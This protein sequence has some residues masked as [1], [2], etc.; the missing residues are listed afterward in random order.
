VEIGLQSSGPGEGRLWTLQS[1]GI[2]KGPFDGTFQ[3]VDRTLGKS[4]LIIDAEGMVSVDVLQIMGG[5]DIAEPFQMSSQ[6][7]QEGSV[8]IIDEDHPGQLKLSNRAYDQRVAGIVSGANGIKAGLT[9][10]SQNIAD[11]GQNV[12]LTGRV[13][14]M[15]DASSSPIRPGDLL[16]TSDT[17]GYCMKMTDNSRGRGAVLGK[18]MTSLESGMGTVLVLVSLQ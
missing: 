4:R 2:T 13:Y 18:A 1:S 8:V 6:D 12:A 11:V 15:A 7:L 3:I 16:T 5:A 9:L 17:P 10:K 14:A